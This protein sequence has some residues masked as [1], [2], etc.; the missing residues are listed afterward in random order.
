MADLSSFGVGNKLDSR[1]NPF[2]EGENDRGATNPSNDSLH[3]IEGPMIR[4]KTKRMMKQ[5]LQG[6]IL[7]IKEKK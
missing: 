3:G 1:T 7:K 6:L 2:K 4:S 5:A